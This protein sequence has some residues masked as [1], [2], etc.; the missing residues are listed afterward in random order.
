MYVNI[1]N[2]NM[3]I[4]NFNYSTTTNHFIEYRYLEKFYIPYSLGGKS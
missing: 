1:A 3:A 4:I 2:F